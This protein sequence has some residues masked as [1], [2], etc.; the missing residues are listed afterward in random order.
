MVAKP[1]D[2]PAEITSGPGATE[3]N[4]HWHWQGGFGNS[5]QKQRGVFTAAGKNG[6]NC[7]I[8]RTTASGLKPGSV[9]EE[10]GFY[11]LFTSV[12]P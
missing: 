5:P 1:G 2:S 7:P 6:N 12:C 9:R 8:L 10:F 11:E 3:P 4:K